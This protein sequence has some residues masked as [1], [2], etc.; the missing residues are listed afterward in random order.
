[1]AW[2]KASGFS[3]TI[4]IG[5]FLRL[6]SHVFLFPGVRVT[7]LQFPGCHMPPCPLCSPLCGTQGMT[8]V[9]VGSALALHSPLFSR[10]SSTDCS[11]S[12]S[13]LNKLGLFSNTIFFVHCTTLF[14]SNLSHIAPILPSDLPF[15][16]VVPEI[17]WALRTT[18]LSRA[19]IWLSLSL[20]LGSH[21]SFMAA[22]GLAVRTGRGTDLQEKFL[23]DRAVS[24]HQKAGQTHFINFLKLQLD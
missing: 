24:Q 13:M 15:K 12:G 4:N 16:K 9:P 11:C 5:S 8:L 3:S 6:V 22:A 10:V 14:H 20:G 2:F 21:S 1:M 19:A 7:L 17:L 23:N 18:S